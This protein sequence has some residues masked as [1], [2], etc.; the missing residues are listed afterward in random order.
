MRLLQDA[1]HSG[2][3]T[4]QDQEISLGGCIILQHIFC[5]HIEMHLCSLKIKEE[6]SRGMQNMQDYSQLF[7]RQMNWCLQLLYIY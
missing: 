2:T 3:D 5:T 6:I 1:N 7:G 4:L